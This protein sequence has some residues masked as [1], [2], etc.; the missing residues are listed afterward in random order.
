MPDLP[1]KLAKLVEMGYQVGVAHGHVEPEE[2]A[3]AEARDASSPER[4]EEDANRLITEIAAHIRS[5]VNVADDQIAMLIAEKSADAVNAVK[6]A[7]SERVEFHERAL[8]IAR[9][10]PTVYVVNGPGVF[11]LHVAIDDKTGDTADERSADLLQS[12]LDTDAHAERVRQEEAG[13]EGGQ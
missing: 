3:L 10:M 9:A 1:R 2:E 8:E 11:G 7:R 6:L 5:T 13:S 12:L 4:I